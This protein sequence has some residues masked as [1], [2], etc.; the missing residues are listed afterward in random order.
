[1]GWGAQRWHDNDEL[2][3]LP[4]WCYP[5]SRECGCAQWKRKSAEPLQGRVLTVQ[6]QAAEIARLKAEGVRLSE[7][8]LRLGIGRASVYRVLGSQEKVAA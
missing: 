8:A 4:V 2:A 3:Q 7:I 6:R 5:S 1:M